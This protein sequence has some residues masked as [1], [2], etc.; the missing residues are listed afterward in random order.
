MKIAQGMLRGNPI[1]TSLSLAVV[2]VLSNLS[3]AQA[4]ILPPPPSPSTNPPPTPEQIAAAYAAMVA[5]QQAD[6][7]NNYAPWIIPEVIGGGPLTPDALEPQITSDLLRQHC[8]VADSS[9]NQFH[10]RV[11]RYK[12]GCAQ[13]ELGSRT[14]LPRAKP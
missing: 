12:S 2:V 6:Y 10:Q 1:I 14:N 5:A 8:A 11:D 7:T 4:Q 3:I 9:L 13:M